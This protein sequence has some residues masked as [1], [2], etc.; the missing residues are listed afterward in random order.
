MLKIVKTDSNNPDF[1]DLV[2]HLDSYLKI[3]DG[4]EHDFYNQYNHIDILKHI[5]IAYLDD[6]PVACGAFKLYNEK[7]IEIKR[8]YAKPEVRGHGAAAILLKTL[9]DWANELGHNYAILETGKRQVEAVKFYKKCGYA[10]IPNYGQYQGMKNSIC[11]KKE[12]V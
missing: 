1:I 8:M 5:A 3:T 4:N 2:K 9:E 10:V 11:Y 6:K 7:C 12:F